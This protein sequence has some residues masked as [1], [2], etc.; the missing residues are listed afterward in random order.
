MSRRYDDP[1]ASES[2][3]RSL[4]LN[5]DPV[6]F[7][8]AGGASESANRG[9]PL[10]KLPGPK[11]TPMSHAHDAHMTEAY[12][13]FKTRLDYRYLVCE[14]INNI[15]AVEKKL[16]MLPGNVTKLQMDCCYASCI[17]GAPLV[18]PTIHYMVRCK[19]T[20]EANHFAL[21]EDNTGDVK[22][23]VIYGPG[24]HFLGPYH[25]L[26]GIYSF[27]KKYTNNVISS[28]VGDLQLVIVEQ[29]TIAHFELGG[30]NIILG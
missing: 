1:H 4:V 30:Q 27:S 20:V 19:F 2:E 8:A 16:A 28:S 5:A 7:R 13:N 29:G 26:L 9:I 23:T 17:L 22:K 14:D 10:G 11:A 3:G 12:R 21:V 18:I 24:Y 6:D 25:S 15:Q